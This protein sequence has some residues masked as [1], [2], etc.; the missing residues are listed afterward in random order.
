MKGLHLYHAQCAGKARAGR[1]YMVRQI[2]GPCLDAMPLTFLPRY[3]T[4]VGNWDIS[5]VHVYP[6]LSAQGLC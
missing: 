1:I 2:C 5:L 4:R 3:P 6:F